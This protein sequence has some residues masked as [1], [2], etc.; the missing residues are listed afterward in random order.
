MLVRSFDVGS[1]T[2]G[3]VADDEQAALYVGEEAVGIWRYGAEPDAGTARVQVDSTSGGHLTADVEGL[4][5]Y[6]ASDGTGY[7][8]ASSQGSSEFVVYERQGGN[9]YVMT[10]EVGSGGG[11]DGVSGTD[12]IDVINVDLGPSFPMGAFAA[13]DNTQR[14]RVTRTT[15]SCRGTRSPA[16]GP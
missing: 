2:E 11:I 8:L 9:D 16:R 1:Q 13:Q 6:H 10:F 3:I 15:S 14:L 12:G 7:L 4:A 5:I